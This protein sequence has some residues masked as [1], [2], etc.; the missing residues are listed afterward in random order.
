M[1]I[2]L[3]QPFTYLSEGLQV[4]VYLGAD[5]KT[6]LKSLKTHEEQKEQ[7]RK[8]GKNP[9]ELTQGWFNHAQTSYTM[10][11]EKLQPETGLMYVHL[12]NEPLPV[13]KIN[14]DG[15]YY[16]ASE[17]QFI[18]QQKVEL[19]CERIKRLMGKNDIEG[20][21]KVIDD[22][23][24]LV[25]KIWNKNITEDTFNFDH[26]YGYLDSDNLVQIDVGSFWEGK[27]YIHKEVRRK[28]LLTMDSAKWL[29]ENF[30]QLTDYYK[31]KVGLLYKNFEEVC[32]K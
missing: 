5:G 11:F 9:D 22:V 28:N 27:E 16:I 2:L 26:N 6:V 19:V 14:L 13:E 7:F 17:S 12:S 18:L 1:K 4:R 24:G 3:S 31:Q 8:W 30:P 25:T 15:K 29:Q 23:V 32:E 20:S 21:R 10:A